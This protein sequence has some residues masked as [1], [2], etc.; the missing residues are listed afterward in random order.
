[1]EQSLPDDPETEAAE[2]AQKRQKLSIDEV[3]SDA[4]AVKKEAIEDTILNLRPLD[5]AQAFVQDGKVVLEA[6]EEKHGVS[7]MFN[8][9][10]QGAICV[11]MLVEERCPTNRY[12]VVRTCQASV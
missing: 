7:M 1:M 5:G 2:R 9:G 3:P 8:I 12:S 6:W 11:M 4:T 10:C